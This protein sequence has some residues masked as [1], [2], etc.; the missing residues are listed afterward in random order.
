M[1]EQPDIKLNSSQDKTLRRISQVPAL[2]NILW[3]DV[4]SLLCTLVDQLGGIIKY[5]TGSIVKVKLPNAKPA[6]FHRPHTKECDKGIIHNLKKYLMQVGI[7]D[8]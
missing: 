7:I 8:D 1:P 5:E 6:I 3:S 2:S 4:D